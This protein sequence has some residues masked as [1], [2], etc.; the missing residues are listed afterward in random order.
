MTREGHSRSFKS[1][2]YKVHNHPHTCRQIYIYI[3]T[4]TYIMHNATTQSGKINQTLPM[5]QGYGPVRYRKCKTDI[6]IPRERGP[7]KEQENKMGY[8]EGD[9]N[10]CSREEA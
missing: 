6:V 1:P 9:P 4:H 10:T 2:S 8:M 5:F 3:Y 7:S